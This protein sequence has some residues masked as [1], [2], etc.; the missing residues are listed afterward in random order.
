ME[1][2]IRV[3]GTAAPLMRINVDTDTIVPSTY[4][5]RTYNEGYAIALFGNWRFLDDGSPNPDFILNQ[6]PWCHATILLTDRN[7]GCGSSREVAPKAVRAFGFR[8]IIAPSFGGIFYNNCFRN[9]IL[10]VELP[11]EQ[12][13]ILAQEME[14]DP[15]HAQVEVD[16]EQ[17]IVRSPSG[18]EFPFKAP[19]LPRRMLLG[20]LDEIDLT[21]TMNDEIQAFR[22]D[23]AAR[24]PWVYDLEAVHRPS[25][26][27]PT[28]L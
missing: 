15:Q 16:L 26:P 7:F 19:A 23:D 5:L 12:V 2:L 18:Q 6:E 20:G 17:Q 13:T 27:D 21:L 24:R 9:G 11:I 28:I 22:K 8:S 10:P 1:Q 3:R 25:L 4:L 14:A